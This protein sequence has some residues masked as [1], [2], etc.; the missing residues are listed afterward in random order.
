MS[1]NKESNNE[2]FHYTTQQGLIG[3]LENNSIWATHY[4]YLNDYSEIFKFKGELISHFCTKSSMGKQ[5][6]SKDKILRFINKM[7]EFL[8]REIYIASFCK[9]KTENPNIYFNGRL[10]QWRAYGEDGGFAIEFEKD[11]LEEQIEKE[12]LLFDYLCLTIEEVIYSSEFEDCSKA[13]NSLNVN[14]DDKRAVY[15]EAFEKE[16]KVI[17]KCIFEDKH[18]ND[19][20]SQIEETCLPFIRCITRYKDC[21]FVEEQE[22]R[23]IAMPAVLEA[24]RPKKREFRNKNGE[25]V[26][27]IELFNPVNSTEL[28]NDYKFTLPIKRII[29]GPHKNKEI[30]RTWLLLK[31]AAMGRTDIQ[32]NVSEIPF[33][34]R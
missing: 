7:Y 27:Y 3:I 20:K 22:I 33:I 2:L 14:F 9:E 6:I 19:K 15:K 21:G 10:S 12:G 13:C 17:E 16:L 4:Q 29:V 25:Q 31:L 32:V 23:I 30:R 8:S 28:N 1:E 26:P 24:I 5:P 34:G 11:K 18:E